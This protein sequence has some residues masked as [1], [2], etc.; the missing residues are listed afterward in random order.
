MS[1]DLRERDIEQFREEYKALA[2]E[3]LKLCKGKQATVVGKALSEANR[4]AQASSSIPES[5][6]AEQA[7]R[8]YGL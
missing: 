3:V 7:Y 4:I 5:F 2:I 6:S 1:D 8:L